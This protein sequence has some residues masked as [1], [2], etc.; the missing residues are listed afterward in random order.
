MCIAIIFVRRLGIINGLP[1]NGSFNEVMV[2]IGKL[3]KL[4]RLVPCLTGDRE[5]TAPATARLFLTHVVHLY[6]VPHFVLHDHDTR[7]TRTFGK[8]CLSCSRKRSSFLLPFYPQIDSHLE[9][10][11][12]TIE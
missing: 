9:R 5:P 2:C 4:I 12:Y 1:T 10:S 11:N 3:T 6:A 7:S 8:R